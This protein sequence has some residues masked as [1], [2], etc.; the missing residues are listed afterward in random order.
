MAFNFSFNLRLISLRLDRDAEWAALG[1]GL[2][3]AHVSCFVGF[4]V[5]VSCCLIFVCLF[6]SLEESATTRLGSTDSIDTGLIVLIWDSC[7]SRLS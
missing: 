1:A 6:L 5:S 3:K 4:V 7:Q 2:L